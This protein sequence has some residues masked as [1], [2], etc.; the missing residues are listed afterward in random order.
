M[1]AKFVLTILLISLFT[2]FISGQNQISEAQKLFAEAE[3]LFNK[4]TPESRAEAVPKFL[5]ALKLWQK[6]GDEKLQVEAL[7]KLVDTYSLNGDYAKA[8]EYSEQLLPISRKLGDK[9]LEAGVLGNMGWYSDA[10][11]DTRKGLA[12]MEKSA[13]LSNQ[14]GEKQRESIALNGTGMLNYNLGEI[15]KAFEI[16]NRVLALKREIGDKR[17]EALTLINLGYAYSTGADLTK[18]VELYEQALKISLEIKDARVESLVINNLGSVWHDSGEY[19]KAFDAYQKSLKMRRE[20]GDKYGEAANLTNIAS[21]YRTLGDFE[22]ALEF[23]GQALEIYRSGSNRRDEARTLS[24]M[25][26]IYKLLGDKTKAL[27]LYSQSVEIQK[28]LENKEGHSIVLRNIGSLYL[29]NNEPQKASENFQQSLK[30]A[31][32]AGDIIGVADVLLL[33]ARA[34]EKLNKMPEAEANFVRALSVQREIGL[35]NDA[36]ET[37]YYLAKFEE[38]NGRRN[39][40]IEKM[41]EVFQ[42]IEDLR[43]SVTEQNLRSTYLAEQQKYFD[44]YIHLLV[45]QHKL[46]PKKGYDAVAFRVSESARARSLLESLG[47]SQAN[48]RTGI[49]P[50]LREKEIFLRQT[51]NAKETQRLTA[52]G[53]K[54]SAEVAVFEKE[55]SDS[56]KKYRDLQTE[57]R[58]KSPQFS[59]LTNPAPLDLKDIQAQ[60]L[61]ENSILLEYFLG[62]ENSYLFAVN[63]NSLEIFE[64]PKREI[65]EKSARQAVEKIKLANST[66]KPDLADLSRIL[67]AP[68]AEKIQNKRLLIVASGVLQYV[69]F[70]ALQSQDSKAKNRFLIET[71]EIVNLPSA[72]VLALLRQNKTRSESPKNLMAILADP[73]FTNDDSRLKLV[74]KQKSTPNDSSTAVMREV[75]ILSPQLRS[76]FGRLRF[77]RLEADA[78]LDL[79]KSKQNFAAMDFAANLKAA[80]SAELQNS[81][82]IHLAT[83]GVIK[84]DFPELSGV[85][86]SLIDEDGNPQDGFLRLHDIY[87]LRLNADLVVLSAC[88]TALGKEIKGEGIVGLTRGFMYSGAPT[89]IASLWKV[90][91][92]ATADLMRLFYEKMFKENLSPSESLRQAQ[93]SMIKEKG[94]SQP[95]YWAGFNLQGDW[96]ARK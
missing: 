10:L 16:Y 31:E 6:S 79:A 12:Y 87:N 17:G 19:Q 8:L 77:S 86:F 44:F 63:K 78:I 5:E 49:S 59:A 88:E 41:T 33:S 15:Q 58:R 65:I 64:L 22:R 51:I 54:K 27:E 84:S 28:S 38:K 73:V 91:D 83:H 67:L 4:K 2:T 62:A 25:G 9:N 24:S 72:S 85:V 61:D 52:A 13:E 32:E 30:L 81:R 36:A 74:A 75:K 35:P 93:I 69:P 94:N 23:I 70:A 20:G 55:I 3:E 1:L 45:S 89:V 21:L 47:E 60:I 39:S 53:Q 43:N 11:G 80:N 26:V 7:N 68:V 34:F 76:D 14:T 46:E 42:I 37:L 56:V 50:D 92:R 57:I 90:E 18:A 48:I 29:D 40:S 82:I 96:Q 95:F 71:N 66:E